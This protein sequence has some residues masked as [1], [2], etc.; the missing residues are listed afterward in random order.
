MKC[1]PPHSC[2]TASL[3]MVIFRSENKHLVTNHPGN[4]QL[5]HSYDRNV[6]PDHNSRHDRGIS[7]LDR[8]C[9]WTLSVPTSKKNLPPKACWVDMLYTR[10]CLGE[11]SATHAATSLDVNK[12]NVQNDLLSGTRTMYRGS[13]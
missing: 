13:K 9:S 8:A 6:L 10:A 3:I 7:S 1:Q 12:I 4:I 2:S 11:Q 5:T